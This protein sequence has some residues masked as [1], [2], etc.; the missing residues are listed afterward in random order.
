M[1][2]KIARSWPSKRHE[3]YTEARTANPRRWARHTRNWNPIEVVTLNPE[4]DSIVNT[5]VEEG[6]R[7][8]KAA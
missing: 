7:K 1:Q 2:A 5:A 8:L 3:L 6:K 4:R